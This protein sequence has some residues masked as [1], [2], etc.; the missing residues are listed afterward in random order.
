MT[1][2]VVLDPSDEAIVPIDWTDSLP[3]TVTLTGTVEHTVPTPLVRISQGTDALNNLSQLKV[4]GMVHGG[5]Y[6]IEA[7]ATLSNGEIINRQ[8]P[9]RGWNS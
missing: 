4:R 1:T 6:M 7:Q 9:V 8:F 3:S 2:I 5:L